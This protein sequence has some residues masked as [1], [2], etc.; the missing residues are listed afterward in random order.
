MQ[1]L[2][3]NIALLFLIIPALSYKMGDDFSVT[4]NGT[5]NIHAW[6]EKV[7]IVNGEG[8]LI[9]NADGSYDL[10]S[11]SIKM[12]VHSIKSPKSTVMNNNTYKALKAD[13][14]PEIHYVLFSPIRAITSGTDEKMMKILGHLTIAGVTNPVNMQVKVSMQ[15]SGKLIFEGSQQ[16]N[17]T[18]YNIVPPTA[19]FGTIKTGNTITIHYKT[20]FNEAR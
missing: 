18:D 8:S 3:L 2:L 7:G 5:S 9:K 1:I 19:L 16:I 15:P 10:M 4:I 11:L 17:M 6:E 13:A 12:N 20:N 14:F